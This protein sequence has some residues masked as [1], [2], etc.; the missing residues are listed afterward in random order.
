L[1]A[2]LGDFYEPIIEKQV[3]EILLIP[4]NRFIESRRGRDN[5]TSD[6]KRSMGIAMND[7][8]IIELLSEWIPG[9]ESNTGFARR[10]VTEVMAFLRSGM[11]LNTFTT[12]VHYRRE[13]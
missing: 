11:S 13:G 6:E 10:F 2:L 3:I 4:H 12:N 9:G 7:D 5:K 1:R 8:S